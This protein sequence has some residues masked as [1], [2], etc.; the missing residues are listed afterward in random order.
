MLHITQKSANTHKKAMIGEIFVS[1]AMLAVFFTPI[2][3]ASDITADT[4]I[5]LVNKAR[6][7]ANIAI[8]K[9][10]DLLQKA[11]E[12]K[13]QDMVDNNYFAHVSPQGKSP[14]FWIEKSD[15]DYSYAGENLAINFTNA[16]D[17]QKAW[18]ESPL[19]KKNIL[20]TDYEETGVA[21][22]RGVID[23]QETTVVV[24]MFG[25][26]IQQ[27]LANTKQNEPMANIAG[28]QSN[29]TSNI[30]AVQKISD[31]MKL[32]VLFQNN[33]PTLMGWFAAFVLALVIIIIDVAAMIHKKHKPLL[34]LHEKNHGL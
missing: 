27:A 18:M 19:H 8:L 33:K 3:Q 23:E 10:N 21:V 6:T 17:E 28:M 32:N 14:W 20:S 29:N 9:K 4:V 5:K 25:K 1:L 11:A 16:E 34:L 22:K 12:Q 13:A 30:S 7:S 15:Y 2:S 31:K 26:Q 24:Q